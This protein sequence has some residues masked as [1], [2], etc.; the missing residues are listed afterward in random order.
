MLV[1]SLPGEG[2]ARVLDLGAA[3]PENLAFFAPWCRT[4]AIAD[5]RLPL[6]M[7]K[8]LWPPPL[9]RPGVAA[10]FD[11]ILAWD[12]LNYLAPDD[13]TKV[14]ELLAGLSRR[15]TRLFGLIYTSAEM[16]TRSGRFRVAGR[17]TLSYG[18]RSGV[19]RAAPRYRE[20]ALLRSL[21]GFAVERVFLL[22]HGVEE[23]VFAYDETPSTRV[24]PTATRRTSSAWP[25]RRGV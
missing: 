7:G 12:L 11:L 9:P 20:P 21:R 25:V 23:Y 13:L 5:L 17:S 1:E 22:R 19:R 2:E 15:G 18:D 10:P 4:Y 3:C 24:P 6:A 14:A 16:P 8:E